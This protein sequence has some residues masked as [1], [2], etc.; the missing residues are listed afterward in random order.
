MEGKGGR[1]EMNGLNTALEAEGG[2]K[3]RENS[4]G[5]ENF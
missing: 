4:E 1:V 3:Q 2:G 5:G